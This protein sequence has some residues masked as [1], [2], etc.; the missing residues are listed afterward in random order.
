MNTR[1][2]PCVLL[3]LVSCVSE[4][5]TDKGTEAAADKGSSDANTVEADPSIFK[6]AGFGSFGASHS[7]Q[8]LGDYTLDNTVPKGPGR[9]YNWGFGNNSR[10]GA[11]VAATF[12]PEVSALLQVVSEYHAD[13][14]Y[15]P[16]IEWANLKYAF[17]PDAYIRFGRISLP[18][19]LISDYR[20]I[21]YSYPWVHPPV[22]LYRELSIT[23]SDGIDAMYRFEM[24]ELRNSIKVIY[25][26]NTLDLPTS[27]SYSEDMRGIFDTLEYNDISFRIGYQ[28]RIS[29]SYNLNT[30][31]TG[32]WIPN[33][34]LS[35]GVNYDPGNWFIMSEWIQRESTNKNGAMYVSSGYRVDKLTPYL[36]YSQNSIA[37]FIPGFA[38]PTTTAI[39]NAQ[40]SQSTISLGVRWDFKKNTDFKLQYDQIQLSDNSNG[41]L[42]NVP[43]GVILYGS[44]FHVI[45]AVVDFLF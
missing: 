8:R 9:S 25:G 41:Y 35:V 27:V 37:S 45:S 19:F 10:L 36:T 12:T 3:A 30:G 14:T 28:E 40:R 20:D 21:G 31:I 5:A 39:Q 43:A 2:I 13:N 33:S 17:T 15:Q 16:A 7:S 42:A 6:F 32:A 18:T 38:A 1:L 29:S 26:K 22:D 4:A 11:Q 24:G 23:H 34:D 44:R